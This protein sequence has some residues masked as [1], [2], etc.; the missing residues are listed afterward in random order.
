MYGFTYIY[1]LAYP[2]VLM[3]TIYWLSVGCLAAILAG[4]AIRVLLVPPTSGE[5][6]HYDPEFSVLAMAARIIRESRNQKPHVH[7]K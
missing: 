1:R 5:H 2:N 3:S 4:V 6:S 7:W